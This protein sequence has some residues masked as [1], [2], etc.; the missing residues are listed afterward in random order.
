M[1]EEIT[2]K[3]PAGE[4]PQEEEVKKQQEPVGAGEQQEPEQEPEFFLDEEG[5]LHINLK[6]WGGE[7]GSA[8]EGEAST[9]EET[10][11]AEPK[12]EPE[13]K[14]ESKP[15][16]QKE[17]QYYTPEEL[18]NLEFSQIDPARVPPE[19]KPYYEA[20]L[21]AEAQKRQAQIQPQQLPDEKELYDFVQSEARK[22][23]EQKLGEQFDELNPKHLTALAIEAAKL[24]QEIEKKMVV[25][26][27]INELRAQEPYFD[28]INEYIKQKLDD[29]P[30]REYKKIMAAI[31]NDDL[32][33]FLPF[34]EKMRKEFYQEKL[35][36]ANATEKI[37]A[38]PKQSQSEPEPP[39]V[40][41]AGKGEVETPP[42]V[43]P[44]DFAK[45]SPEEQAE[46]LIKLGII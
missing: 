15:E 9:G 46:A 13:S 1:S 14:P 44:Q 28:Q 21:K 10:V 17:V 20:I 34:W 26:R 45:M 30:A 40:E 35:G 22:R 4:T 29:L 25:Q 42:T 36:K 19:L 23:V 2:K 37:Q 41:G 16:P 27:K 7:E 8:G 43:K 39:K 32:D 18:A 3:D 6:D 38:Q 11:K 24:T 33:V 31:Q 12:P 5:N